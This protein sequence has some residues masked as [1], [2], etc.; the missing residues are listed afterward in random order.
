MYFHEICG[1]VMYLSSRKEG[2]VLFNYAHSTLY[3][4]LYVV[5][6]MVKDN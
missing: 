1:S 6:H 5:S 3:L 4:R 2:N